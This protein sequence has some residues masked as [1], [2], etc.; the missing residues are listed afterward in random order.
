MKDPYAVLGVAQNASLDEV[1]SAYRALVK[2]YHPDNYV[3]NPLAD[4]AEEKMKEINEAYDTIV[5]QRTSGNYSSENASGSSRGSYSGASKYP[6]IRSAILSGN[7]ALAESLLAQITNRDAEWNFL[8]GSV[9]LKKGWFDSA[10]TYFSKA[11]SMEPTNSEYAEAFS[12]MQHS[13]AGTSTTYPGGCACSPCDCCSAL[14]CAD[15][16]CDCN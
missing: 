10:R 15:C 5:K 6:E 14:L 16:L 2:K 9:M 4:L 7:I 3:N 11:Y 12:R 13:G 8:M 1:K